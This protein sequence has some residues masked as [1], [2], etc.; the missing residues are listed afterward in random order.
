ALL[1]ITY[2]LIAELYPSKYV[3]V[4]VFSILYSFTTVQLYPM[5]VT[6]D[7]NATFYLYCITSIIA[8]IFITIALLETRGKTKTQI[9]EVF[10]GKLK[11]EETFRKIEGAC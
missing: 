2:S 5:M 9:E 10:R 7:R 6:Q 4:L 1:S 3:N 11:I 8:T